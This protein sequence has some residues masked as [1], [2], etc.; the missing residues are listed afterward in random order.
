MSTVST[1]IHSNCQVPAKSGT[2]IHI[3]PDQPVTYN[4]DDMLKL[5]GS[6]E[7]LVKV[8]GPRTQLN[9]DDIAGVYPA[10]ASE[11]SADE[12]LP[13]ISLTRR[14]LPWERFG[15]DNDPVKPWLA[16]VVYS[17][18]ELKLTTPTT[19]QPKGEP[20]AV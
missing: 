14:T 9:V 11:E 15:V 16:L 1:Q 12:F 6:K 17:S 5:T 7:V 20:Q 18:S 4:G 10:P 3:K 13:H 19:P 2:T 8:D